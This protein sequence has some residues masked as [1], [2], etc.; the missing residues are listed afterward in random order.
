[1]RASFSSQL[2]QLGRD[3]R[4][5]ETWYGYLFILPAAVLLAVFVFFPVVYAFIISFQRWSLLSQ[6]RWIGLSNYTRVFQSEAFWTSLSNTVF[7]MLGIPIGLAIGLGLALVMNSK[8]K[9]V[10]FYRAV[11]F[12]PGITSIVAVSAVFKYIY[13]PSYGLANRFLKAVGLSGIGWLSSPVWV[14]PA[15]ILMSLWKGMGWTMIIYLAGLQGI[16]RSYY[17]AATID[18]ASKWGSFR[19]IT[20]P[21]LGPTT[22]FLLIMETINTLKKFEDVYVLT[23]GGPMDASK[24]LTLYIFEEA[25][26]LFHFGYASAVAFVLFLIVLIITLIQFKYFGTIS[27]VGV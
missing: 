12:A 1:M 21:L 11:Y 2:K 16:P 13:N 18:G 4:M 24:T 26:E 25:F 10:S 3:L 20:W 5:K 9:G 17:E 19:H 8:I 14:K 22:F 23:R 7:Y 15:I 27:D 6:R